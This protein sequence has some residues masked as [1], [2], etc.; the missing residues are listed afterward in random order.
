M[1]LGGEGVRGE[2]GVER[3]G[4]GQGGCSVP[5]LHHLC[6]KTTP[7]SYDYY[8]TKTKATAASARR[9]FLLWPPLTKSVA[10]LPPSLHTPFLHPPL[11]FF[12]P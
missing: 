7:T 9:S 10:P 4:G 8:N 1:P 3:V 6:I 5:G 12:P 11:Q 2:N